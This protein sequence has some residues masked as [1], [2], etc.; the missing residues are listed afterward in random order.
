MLERETI[1]R[2]HTLHAGYNHAFL[3]ALPHGLVHGL[4]NER[5]STE[6][7]T[8]QPS[9]GGKLTNGRGSYFQARPAGSAQ[10]ADRAKWLYIEFC[11][12]RG[13]RLARELYSRGESIEHGGALK[14][15]FFQGS[16]DTCVFK[17]SSCPSPI[18]MYR[19]RLPSSQNI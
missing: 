18:L 12:C 1:G 13:T 16:F 9:H 17:L 10:F 4:A 2:S 14:S 3:S 15:P 7:V 6:L 19:P 11:H 8:M 5:D